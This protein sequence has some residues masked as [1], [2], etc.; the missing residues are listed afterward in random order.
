MSNVVELNP[1][2][3]DAGALMD[4]YLRHQR[5]FRDGERD[6]RR[7]S[8]GISEEGWYASSLGSCFRQQYLQR[9]GV[10]RLRKIDADALRTFAWGDHVEDFIR[11]IYQRLGLVEST[12]VRLAYGSLV[13]RGD[14]LLRFPPQA[15]SDIP[16]DVKGDWSPEWLAFLKVMREEVLRLPYEGL[17]HDEIKSTHSRAMRF[18]F[19]EGKPRENHSIQVGA[20]IALEDLVADAVRPDFHQVTY[21]GKDAVGC[22]RFRVGDEWGNVALARWNYL[23]AAWSAS[24]DPMDVQCE[25]IADPKQKWKITYCSYYDGDTG[26]CCGN[27]GLAQSKLSDEVQW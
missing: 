22:L 2:P 1:A 8:A 25:C 23:D 19:K 17:V 21:V 7:A 10:E 14:L 26:T 9:K 11:K 6:A 12:Q 15:V 4:L 18:L 16:D 5:T 3:P 13:A 27:A 20:S 24:A